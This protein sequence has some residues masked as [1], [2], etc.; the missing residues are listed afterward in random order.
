MNTAAL[1]TLNRWWIRELLDAL[2]RPMFCVEV[3]RCGLWILDEPSEQGD[4]EDFAAE[5]SS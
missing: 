2:L 1:L 5:G 4:F 3:D